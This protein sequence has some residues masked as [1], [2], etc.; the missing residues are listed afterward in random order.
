MFEKEIS[1]W[2]TPSNHYLPQ[3]PLEKF[4]TL[5]TK[6]S[7]NFDKAQQGFTVNFNEHESPLIWTETGGGRGLQLNHIVKHA[8]LSPQNE[9]VTQVNTSNELGDLVDNLHRTV[10]SLARSVMKTLVFWF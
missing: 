4:D 10:A 6:A 2:A 3:I 1:H 5:I 8:T 9:L 7:T